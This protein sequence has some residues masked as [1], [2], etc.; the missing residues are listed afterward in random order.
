MR[1]EVFN[2]PYTICIIIIF[3]DKSFPN[4]TREF[5]VIDDKSVGNVNWVTVF[6]NVDIYGASYDCGKSSLS[7]I[8]AWVS[9]SVIEF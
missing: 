7:N 1:M 8:S 9:K 2:R 5:V 3:K 4:S 6:S